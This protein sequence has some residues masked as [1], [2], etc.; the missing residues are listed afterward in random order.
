MFKQLYI[1]V[2]LALTGKHRASVFNPEIGGFMGKSFGFDRSIEGFQYLL[3]RVTPKDC[4]NCKLVFTMEPTSMAWLPLSVFLITK[5]HTVFRVK[6]QK[7]AD[8]RRYFRKHTKSDRIDSQTLAKL[9]FIDNESLNEL[10]LP[11]PVLSALDRYCRQRDKIMRNISAIKTRIQAIFIFVNPKLMER[12][13]DDKFTKAAR[14]LMRNYAD[15]F[16]IKKIGLKRLTSFLNNHAHGQ[17]KPEVI[18]KIFDASISATEIYREAKEANTL[19]VDFSQVQEEINIELDRLEFEEQQIDKLDKKIRELYSKVDPDHILCSQPGMSK[20]I[21]PTILGAVGDIDRF[22]NIREFKCFCGNTPRKKQTNETDR[23]GLPITGAASKLLKKYLHLASET[24]RKYDVEYA[25][26]YHGLRAKGLHHNQAITALA[27]KMAG[28]TY[29]LLKRTK[30]GGVSEEEIVYQ[31]RDLNGKTIEK[32]TARALVI[33]NY[34][35]KNKGRGAN[36]ELKRGS[37][38]H[39][40]Q[41]NSSNRNGY[42]L[43]RGR[44]NNSGC[45]SRTKFK[46]PKDGNSREDN[47]S[48]ESSFPVYDENGKIMK[49]AM[50]PVSVRTVTAQVMENLEKR[51]QFLMAQARMLGVRR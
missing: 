39:Q 6:P 17:V 29:S 10:Y 33:E 37:L 35:S 46:V 13:A 7:V 22:S 41:D 3:Q 14:A 15:P 49:Y 5:G 1:G 48:K 45:L 38:S 9:P 4:P 27:D 34:P 50:D 8:L 24:A 25:A 44:Y 16:A 43:H 11:T 36:S 31:F 26:F 42:P 20:V 30:N 32:E 51:R 12:F 18:Q 2:D 21:A 23:K 28:R 19:P 40:R 47:E